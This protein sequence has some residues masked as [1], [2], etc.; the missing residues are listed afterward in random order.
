MKFG[1]DLG[2]KLPTRDFVVVGGERRAKL[3]RANSL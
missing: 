1:S 3:L 2:N